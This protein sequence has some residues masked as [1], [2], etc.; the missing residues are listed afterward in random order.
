MD[1]RK[2]LDL[3]GLPPE[4]L[5][6]PGKSGIDG[7]WLSVCAHMVDV[8][9]CILWLLDVRYPTLYKDSGL[10]EDEFRRYAVLAGLDHDIGKLIVAFLRSILRSLPGHRSLLSRYGVPIPD[11]LYMRGC[12]RHSL[13]GE[14][15]LRSLGYPP[16]F[17]SLTGAHHGMPTPFDTNVRTYMENHVDDYWG[18]STDRPFW[19]YVWKAWSDASLSMTGFG[20]ASDV[21]GILPQSSLVLLSGLLV[22][23][24][25][26][27]SNTAY[28]DL[29]PP[30]EILDRYAIGRAETGISTAGLTSLWN[31]SDLCMTDAGFESRFGFSPN[32]IQ[33]EF[34]DIVRQATTPGLFILEAPMGRGKTEAA[35]AGAEILSRK[36]SKHGV[37]F[38]LPTQAT[39]NSMFTRVMDWA[40]SLGDP[41]F[42]SINLVHGM[43]SFN[44]DFMSVQKDLPKVDEDVESGLILQGFF[45]GP[46]RA[47]LSDFC[48]GTVDR[49]LMMVLRKCHAMLLHLGLYN[50]VVIVDEVHAYDVHMSTYL[51][52]SLEWLGEYRVPVIL[53]SATLT[54]SRRNE[55]L[56]AYAGR[57]AKDINITGVSYPRVSCATRVG[58]VESMPLKCDVPRMQ[59]EII[60]ITDDDSVQ[61]VL[62]AATAAGACAGVIVNSVARAQ[63]FSVVGR[64]VGGNPVVLYHSQFVAPDRIIREKEVLAVAGKDVALEIRQG[65]IIAGTQVLEQSLNLN[66][67]VLVVDICPIDLLLQRIG[68]EFRYLDT[69]RPDGYKSPRCYV[70]CSEE[71][72]RIASRIYG[73]WPIRQTLKIL[74]RFREGDCICLPDDISDLVEEAYQE[75]GD[76]SAMSRDDQ[77][78][79]LKWR[80]KQDSLRCKARSYLVEKPFRTSNRPDRQTL[81]GLLSGEIDGVGDAGAAAV[82]DGAAS[83]DVIVLVSYNDGSVGF[84]P[85][86]DGGLPRFSPNVTPDTDLAEKIA[87]EVLRLGLKLSCPYAAG[88]TLTELG[89]MSKHVE[90]FQKSPW[91]KDSLFL[92]L[93]EDLKAE[94]C[95]HEL[96]YTQEDGLVAI[97]KPE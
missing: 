56:A 20:S 34:L 9:H 19:E 51:D 54:S 27:A 57:K 46:K 60:P 69:I 24:D 18:S 48:I 73:E 97:E 72:I 3:A 14:T 15:I 55:L 45:C 92:L 87:G 13:A 2:S 16:G 7:A 39:A 4:L 50:K 91:L 86:R 71:A 28:F 26:M 96:T 80:E 42:H 81:H 70:L 90:A 43:S 58:N 22:L 94:L 52:R 30:D 67:D 12:T 84:L 89:V 5:V 53:L 17:A 41:D 29:L 6:L 93:N 47:L 83:I 38:G 1:F 65:S 78:A 95:G 85:W 82:R 21:P 40:E 36:F 25:W 79:W 61:K 8:A 23:A 59:V 77:S 62:S 37:F 44:S 88:R 64:S 33:K 10:S 35:L 68:R 32:S 74:S 49:L 11:G 76:F 63:A 75:P 31:G 66:F